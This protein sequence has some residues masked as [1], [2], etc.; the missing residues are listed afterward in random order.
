MRK[1][2]D[3][4]LNLR[5]KIKEIVGAKQ[6]MAED[7]VLENLYLGRVRRKEI[8]KLSRMEE[9]K[10]ISLTK[11]EFEWNDVVIKK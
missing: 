4:S 5:Q 9:R 11:K 3:K 1:E 6:N 2:K 8:L 7:K 10:Q